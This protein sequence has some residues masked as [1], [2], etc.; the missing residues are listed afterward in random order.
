MGIPGD[1]LGLTLGSTEGWQDTVVGPIEGCLEGAHELGCSF[2]WLEDC[3]GCNVDGF[4][5]ECWKDG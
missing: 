3:K 1:E 2:G 4:D 5:E